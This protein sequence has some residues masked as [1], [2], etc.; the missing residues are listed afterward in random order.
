MSG[1]TWY[2]HAVE[3]GAGNW[4][5]RRGLAEYDHHRELPDA[6]GHLA[7]IAEATGGRGS[8]TL[9]AHHLDGTIE[10]RHATDVRPRH[11][12]RLPPPSRCPP[13]PRGAAP[14]YG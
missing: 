11:G 3:I 9:M 8:Y 10:T 6:F 13:R 7:A 2:L 4:L 1:V 12:H 14:F 5:C